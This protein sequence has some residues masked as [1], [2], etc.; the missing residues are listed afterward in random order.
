[1]MDVADSFVFVDRDR[2]LLKLYLE[3][4]QRDRN[5]YDY[6]ATYQI[7]VGAKGFD[8]PPGCYFVEEKAK[9]KFPEWKMPDSP[10][11][12]AELRGTVVPGGDPANPIKSRWIRLTDD[13]VGI[14]GTDNLAS[15]GS[16][17]SHGCIR[18][19]VGDIE[20]LYPHVN[21]GSLVYIK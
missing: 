9:A 14:H 17:A 13:G 3:P 20:E 1:M 7:A 19:A 11:V 8:T 5:R 4:E 2:C 10:W 6:F 21:A 18:M 16:R 12:P 15:L